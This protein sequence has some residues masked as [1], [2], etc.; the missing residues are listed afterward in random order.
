M[1]Q[2]HPDEHVQS[3]E[4]GSEDDQDY[5]RLDPPFNL[6]LASRTEAETTICWDIDDRQDMP[7]SKRL[8]YLV[9]WEAVVDDKIREEFDVKPQT[10]QIRGKQALT[11]NSL[12]P[13][14]KYQFTVSVSDSSK[15]Y[16]ASQSRVLVV[17][18]VFGFCIFCFALLLFFYFF[19]VFLFCC[20]LFFLR[21]LILLFV[22]LIF[23]LV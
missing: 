13:N 17:N 21:F 23:C 10:C 2:V 15:E 9:T 19:S 1:H 16:K 8:N 11:I 3:S 12:D 7:D 20:A 6:R 4:E 18:G 5:L 14:L 22:Y